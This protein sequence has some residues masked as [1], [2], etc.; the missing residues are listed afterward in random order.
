MLFFASTGV[1]KSS[2]VTSTDSPATI[3]LMLIRVRENYIYVKFKIVTL[4]VKDDSIKWKYVE[5]VD[6]KGADIGLSTLSLV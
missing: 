2:S 3:I 6:M 4:N 5:S 1:A